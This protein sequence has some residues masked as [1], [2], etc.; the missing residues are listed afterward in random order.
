[1]PICSIQRALTA[2]GGPSYGIAG[3]DSLVSPFIEIMSVEIESHIVPVEDVSGCL[4][5]RSQNG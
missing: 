3:D 4:S 5:V 1:M 2:D